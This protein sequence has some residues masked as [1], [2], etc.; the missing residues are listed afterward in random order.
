M[1][2]LGGQQYIERPAAVEKAGDAIANYGNI[3]NS[4]R[5]GWT[6]GDWSKNRTAA[7][8]PSTQL[9][10]IPTQ[11]Y[12]P[13]GFRPR[14]PQDTC[15]PRH[16]RLTLERIDR[17]KHEPTISSNTPSAK[18]NKAERRAKRN[19]ALTGIPNILLNDVETVE[20]GSYLKHRIR[21][22]PLNSS[23]AQE[24]RSRP[25]SSPNFPTSFPHSTGSR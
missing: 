15:R 12:G 16:R 18:P 6:S 21:A 17:G 2:A 24:P 10:P 4:L 19:P 5:Q 20:V 8:T 14:R 22:E 11:T 3:A 25:A 1:A 13:P 7:K 23:C 9:R